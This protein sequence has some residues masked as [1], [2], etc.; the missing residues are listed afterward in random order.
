MKVAVVGAGISGLSAAWLLSQKHEVHLFESENRLGGHAHTVSVDSSD[1]PIP[2]D[3]GFLVYNEL[4]YPHLTAFFKA[5]QVETVNSDMSLS[6]R[7]EEKGL[8]WSGTNLNTVFGQRSNL[9]RPRFHRML[10]EILRFGREAEANLSQSRRHGWTLG[11]LLR[12]RRFSN[13]FMTDYLVPIGA[14]IWSMPEG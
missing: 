6:V 8:E 3:T 7:V 9:L 5:L 14:A 10:L 12:N 2:M 13:E 1:G 11:E 4:T